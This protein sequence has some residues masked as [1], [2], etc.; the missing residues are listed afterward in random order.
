MPPTPR[1]GRPHAGGKPG[2]AAAMAAGLPFFATAA[3]A[4]IGSVDLLP[5]PPAVVPIGAV[6]AVAVQ[7]LGIVVA[8]EL[9]LDRWRR[10]WWMALACTVM[11][12]PALALQAALSRTP[13][14]SWGSGS[15]GPLLW[16]SVATLALLAAMWLWTA[17]VTGEE[18]ERAAILWL[19]A[20]LLIPAVQATPGRGIDERAGLLALAIA[21][22]VAGAAVV[23]GEISPPSALPPI[24]LAAF[25]GGIGL[26]WALGRLPSFPPNQGRVVPALAV[27]LLLVA[28][29]S[30]AAAPLAARAARRFADLVAEVTPVSQGR[31]ATRDRNGPTG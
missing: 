26:L 3:A 1:L 9:D 22:A 30:L 5:V 19:P 17:S 25:V 15:A 7:A 2:I 10:L 24:A 18:P 29:A 20:A 23:L 31:A 12:L 4:A 16:T 28:I 21:C 27:L 11:L 13:F 14:V 6:L 8:R